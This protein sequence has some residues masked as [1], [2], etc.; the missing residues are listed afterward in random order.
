MEGKANYVL[1]QVPSQ[2]LSASERS[3]TALR[4][5]Q[6]VPS[7]KWGVHINAKYAIYR[8]LHMLHITL[9]ISAYFHCNFFLHI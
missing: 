6:D 1:R 7:A 9:H 2:W 8:L 4:L 3:L 5:I